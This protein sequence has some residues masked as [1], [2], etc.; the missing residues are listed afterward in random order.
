[1]TRSVT[2]ASDDGPSSGN[3]LKN[4]N[5]QSNEQKQM[6]QVAAYAANETEQP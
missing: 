6:N 1:M 5:H 3:Q 4:Q 2:S